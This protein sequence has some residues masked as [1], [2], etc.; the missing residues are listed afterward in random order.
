MRT[1]YLKPQLYNRLY[2]IM[3]YKNVLALRVSLETGLR[4]DDVLGLK[5]ENIKGRTIRGVAEK[6]GKA[7]KKTI[8]QE[9]AN[10]LKEIGN[11]YYIFEGRNN[12]K[13]HRT[14]Q[15]VWKDVKKA[16]KLLKI[17]G[18]IAPHSARKTY[19]VELFK[20]SGIDKVQKELQHDKVSTTMIYAF[21]DLLD[22][23]GDK[24]QKVLLSDEQIEQIAE[25]TAKKITQL[26]QAE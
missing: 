5:P 20:D 24:Y 4:I 22:N 14:R 10:R 2:G 18:N 25:K 8:S 13:E 7:F 17:D 26:L 6:T 16:V 23:S 11:S 9:L 12:P 21:A 15:A 3:Q 1:Q 19:A